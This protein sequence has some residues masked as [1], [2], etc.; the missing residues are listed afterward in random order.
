MTLGT[1]L[2]KYH[3]LVSWITVKDNDAHPGFERLVTFMLHWCATIAYSGHYL[4]T[5]RQ[6]MHLGLLGIYCVLMAAAGMK[7]VGLVFAT[8]DSIKKQH[9]R[10]R[11]PSRYAQP[12]VG[13]WLRVIIIVVALLLLALLFVSSVLSG[14][15]LGLEEKRENQWFWAI[16]L[17]QLA[18]MFVIEPLFVS[19]G[20]CAYGNSCGRVY[21]AAAI[22]ADPGVK[23]EELEE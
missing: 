3:T 17:G 13:R 12:W 21:R 5:H 4:A 22:G 20:W 16:L 9:L 2:I 7:L 6:P 15:V 14:V 19:F 10:R 23:E 18:Y 11:E 1:H 8:T